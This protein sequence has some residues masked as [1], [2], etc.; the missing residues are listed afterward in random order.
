MEGLCLPCF[1]ERGPVP[2]DER[3]PPGWVALRGLPGGGGEDAD[4]GGLRAIRH[5]HPAA[6][7]AA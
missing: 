6:H 2:G 3:W 7:G 4:G 1:V 5:L